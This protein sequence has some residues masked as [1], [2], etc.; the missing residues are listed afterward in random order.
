MKKKFRIWIVPATML[1]VLLLVFL[2]DINL[3]DFNLGMVW[4]FWPFYF[5]LHVLAS[6]RALYELLTDPFKWN[7]TEHFEKR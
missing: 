4:I 7:K 6:Y 5:T 1:A 3:P 2:A